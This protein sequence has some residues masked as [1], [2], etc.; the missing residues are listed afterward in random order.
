[1]G[2]KEVRL[3]LSEEKHSKLKAQKG[4]AT[5]REAVEAGCRALAEADGE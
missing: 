4:G 5:W 3:T 2:T 1:M